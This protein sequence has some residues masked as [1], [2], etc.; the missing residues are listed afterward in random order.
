M[1]RVIIR[2]SSPKPR[3]IVKA[4]VAMTSSGPMIMYGGG[5][6]A[7]AQRTRASK[8]LGG[9]GTALGAGLGALGPHRSLG[10]LAQGMQSGAMQG[11]QF[12][13]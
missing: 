10:S 1:S 12:G 2:K 11:S 5:G 13:N 3:V 4:E 7:P 9:V 6:G 8:F